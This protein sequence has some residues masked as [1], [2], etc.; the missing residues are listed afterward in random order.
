MFVCWVSSLPTQEMLLWPE[1]KAVSVLLAAVSPVP[2][3]EWVFKNAYSSSSF[4]LYNHTS[5]ILTYSA[6]DLRLGPSGN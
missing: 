4:F 2:G 1:A 3:V 6:I 5:S